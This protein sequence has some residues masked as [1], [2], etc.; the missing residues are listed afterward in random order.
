DAM[1]DTLFAAR[2]IPANTPSNVIPD[3]RG[4]N[5]MREGRIE[6]LVCTCPEL[7]SAAVG[8]SGIALE[9]HSIESCVM[10]RHEHVENFLLVVLHGSDKCEVLTGARQLEFDAGPGTTFILPKGTV[11][12]VRWRGPTQRITAAINDRLLIG[13]ID[14]VSDERGIELTEHW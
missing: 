12:E 11:D 8:W 9:S 4:V 7:T 13:A 10:H 14:E 5:V 1:S 3:I 2:S 6:P